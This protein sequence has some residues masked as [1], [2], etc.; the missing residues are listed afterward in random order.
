M[1]GRWE[2]LLT[3]V[4]AGCAVIVTTLVVRQELTGQQP[5]SEP[6]VREV[7]NWERLLSEAR[8]LGRQDAALKVIEFADYQCPFCAQAETSLNRLRQR[9]PGSVS[10]FFFHRPLE[11][12]HS[13][14]FEAAMAAE[15]AGAQGRFRAFHEALLAHQ[16]SI[17]EWSWG[18]YGR[19]ADVRNLEALGTCVTSGQFREEV[20]QDIRLADS[21]GVRSTPTFIVAGRLF[22]GAVPPERSWDEVVAAALDNDKKDDSSIF[23][24][25]QWP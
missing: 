8:V 1:T 4:L 16:D 11:R 2:N 25:L 3:G 15:C 18:R 6:N 5:S 24:Q 10:I 14:A 20:D 9:Y 19:V 17:G 21:L 7:E 22:S 13:H 12:L 23:D